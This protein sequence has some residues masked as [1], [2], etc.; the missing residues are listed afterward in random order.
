MKDQ[1]LEMPDREQLELSEVL[2]ALSD[3]IR[4]EILSALAAQGE[5]ACGLIP[6]RVSDS[7][8]SHHFKILRRA[9]LTATRV[10]G[11]QRLVSLRR[12]DLEARFPGLLDSV[13]AAT[14]AR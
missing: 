11:T 4:L 2:E 6:L 12:D 5:V 8:R 13:L 10:S 3:P 1:F 7:T 14:A 9:G